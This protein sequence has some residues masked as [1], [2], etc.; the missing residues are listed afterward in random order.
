MVFLKSIVHRENRSPTLRDFALIDLFTIIKT[1][2]LS[3]HALECKFTDKPLNISFRWLVISTTSGN[4]FLE[5][6][7]IQSPN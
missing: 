7:K 1:H 3:Y 5:Y 4:A 6:R 2:A